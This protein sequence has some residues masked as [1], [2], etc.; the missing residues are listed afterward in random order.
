MALRWLRTSPR[1]AHCF[2]V[3]LSD[4]GSHTAAACLRV[5]P[6]D[7]QGKVNIHRAVSTS[8]TAVLKHSIFLTTWHFP[9]FILS[10]TFLL[11]R[12]QHSSDTM[13]KGVEVAQEII[14]LRPSN[15]TSDYI[16]LQKSKARLQINTQMCS[17]IHERIAHRSQKVK[18]VQVPI[19]TWTR[20][21]KPNGMLLTHRQKFWHVLQYRCVL[22]IACEISHT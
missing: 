21:R 4:W 12:V 15:Y 11:V 14:I 10:K 8:S 1:V 22:K 19:S 7:W 18:V 2:A 20:S 16:H 17:Y 5:C 13:E 9:T 6:R 3:H